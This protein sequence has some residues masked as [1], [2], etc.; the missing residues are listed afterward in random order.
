MKQQLKQLQHSIMTRG[1]LQDVSYPMI[2]LSVSPCV[3]FR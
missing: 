1:T 3:C 2:F